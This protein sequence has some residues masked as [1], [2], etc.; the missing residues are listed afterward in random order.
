MQLA[1]VMIEAPTVT[2]GGQVHDHIRTWFDISMGLFFSDNHVL[3]GAV[4]LATWFGREQLASILRGSAVKG[5]VRAVVTNPT[6]TRSET[7]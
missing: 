4:V 3:Y 2:E 6:R 1:V 5:N 7:H